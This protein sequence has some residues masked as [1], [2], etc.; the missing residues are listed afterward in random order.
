MRGLR[1]MIALLASGVVFSAIHAGR[2]A[3]LSA[4]S[5][6]DRQSVEM[7]CSFAKNGGP[8]VYHACLNSQLARL[9]NGHA[10]DLTRLSVD[11]RQSVEMACS[12]AKN[13]GPAVY[14]ACLNSQLARLGNGHARPPDRELV[15]SELA[16]TGDVRQAA[17][18]PT[19]T[20]QPDD[21]KENETFLAQVG[22]IAPF[23]PDDR[24]DYRSL[25]RD[26]VHIETEQTLVPLN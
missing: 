11:D 25:Y 16:P 5:P 1:A 19:I 26:L 13:G 3:D 10:P 24:L 14:H 18:L 9:G 20:W 8:A 6:D 4:L 15:N 7:A 17:G 2:G 23:E 12:F 21:P 22:P